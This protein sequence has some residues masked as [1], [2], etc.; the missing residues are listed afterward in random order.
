MVI[1]RGFLVH[2]EVV[3]RTLTPITQSEPFLCS[4]WHL[5]RQGE[6]RA[7]FDL[8][9]LPPVIAS[10]VVRAMSALSTSQAYVLPA[11]VSTKAELAPHLR[12]LQDDA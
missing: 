9:A 3:G 12:R 4:I 5:E 7:G 1:F 6:F 2:Q 11:E 10:Q 8:G